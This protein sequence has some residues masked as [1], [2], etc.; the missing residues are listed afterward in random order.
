M[1]SFNLKAAV[2]DLL[3]LEVDASLEGDR[4]DV[5]VD[6]R[7]YSRHTLRTQS[8]AVD[9]LVAAAD[10]EYD[11]A[12]ADAAARHEQLRLCRARVL[13]SVYRTAALRFDLSLLPAD[14]RKW[15]NAQL[16]RAK[17]AAADPARRQDAELARVFIYLTVKDTV[18]WEQDQQ[19][20]VTLD[21]LVTASFGDARADGVYDG[22]PVVDERPV[23]TVGESY[24]YRNVA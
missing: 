5:L 21:S 3:L 10:A 11:E 20:A 17:A 19:E 6:F 24:K 9:A 22:G 15:A 8:A 7:T 1:S 13:Y 16:A 14:L 4:P 18:A 2:L 23:N 12:V